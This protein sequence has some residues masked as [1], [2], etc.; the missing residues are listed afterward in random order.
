MTICTCSDRQLEQVG[1][2]CAAELNVGTSETVR[3]QDTG[4]SYDEASARLGALRRDEPARFWRI[5]PELGRHGFWRVTHEAR[6]MSPSADDCARAE[7]FTHH[8]A[9]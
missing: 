6:Y 1:C 4:L 3:R 5:A 7:G 8:A 2:E 9:G